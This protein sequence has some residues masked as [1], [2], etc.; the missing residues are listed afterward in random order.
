MI[1]YPNDPKNSTKDLLQL[2]N[3]LSKVVGYKI[4]Y[5]SINQSINQSSSSV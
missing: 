4:N 5:K 1:V 3:T 2:T